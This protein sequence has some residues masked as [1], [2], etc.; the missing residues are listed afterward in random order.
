MRT[1]RAIHA[2][3]RS[4]AGAP[5]DRLLVAMAL[6]ALVRQRRLWL[7]ASPLIAAVPSL[8]RPKLKLWQAIAAALARNNPPP[9]PQLAE[10]KVALKATQA[11]RDA[12]A[13]L[14]RSAS[15]PFG[16]SV[17]YRA[18]LDHWRAQPPE[19]LMIFHHHDRRGWLPRSWM[20]A[21]LAIGQA[22]WT[23]VLSSNDLQPHLAQELEQSGIVLALRANVGL[24][25]GAYKDLALL[26]QQDHGLVAGLRSLVL[27]NDSTLPV[28]PAASLISQLEAWAEVGESSERPLLAGMTD[29][30]QR[31]AYHL[32]SYLL[33]A[34]GA[35]V[36]HPAWLRFWLE[37]RVCGTKDDLINTGEIGLSQVALA[38][39]VTISCAYPLIAGLLDG[40]AMADE[41]LGFGIVQP[42]HVNQTLFAW[43]NLLERG[44][45]LIKKH[46]LFDLVENQGHPM[47]I[48]TLAR[49]IPP[50][51][52]ALL[53]ADL[54]ELFVS[55]YA[56]TT[57]DSG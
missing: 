4:L 15:S 35:L 8:G 32:Q 38:A 46:V 41:L 48:A 57:P 50:A 36:Q 51:R 26:L 14:A 56:F 21:L 25:L 16:R 37:F 47:A 20:E 45:P 10:V 31:G 3:V 42:K 5:G 29:S 44:F 43:Q 22:G 34:N 6:V 1:S 53:A 54:Q 23:V 13:R 39:G 40:E 12:E 52:R 30:A 17:H 49:W 19:R 28:A 55:R 18:L 2:L 9:P 11:Y 33:Y 27:C 7:K 24:C